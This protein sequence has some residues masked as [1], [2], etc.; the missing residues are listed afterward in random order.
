MTDDDF[1]HWDLLPNTQIVKISSTEQS[2]K[3]R[4]VSSALATTWQ[5]Y[6]EAAREPVPF[7]KRGPESGL[8]DAP[9]D[10]MSRGAQ[11]PP[12]AAG[13]VAH[14]WAGHDSDRALEGQGASR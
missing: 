7:E 12:G 3:C 4:T 9:E 2:P 6:H 1:P 5:L 10:R 11:L 13:S 8:E 14:V